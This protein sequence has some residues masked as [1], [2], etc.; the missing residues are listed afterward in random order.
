[1][2]HAVFA[3]IKASFP[4]VL[5]LTLVGFFSIMIMLSFNN[6]LYQQ[7]EIVSADTFGAFPARVFDKYL[8]SNCADVTR[9][10]D[11]FSAMC[12][13]VLYQ[14]SGNKIE[15]VNFATTSDLYKSIK[16]GDTIWIVFK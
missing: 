3:R 6:P 14:Y 2:I 1:M 9:T 4:E 15:K 16:V 13:E 5:L 11:D 12:F 8:A 7:V 10:Q